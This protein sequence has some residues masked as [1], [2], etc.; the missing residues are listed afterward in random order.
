MQAMTNNKVVINETGKPI[1]SKTKVSTVT[2]DVNTESYHTSEVIRMMNQPTSV[3]CINTPNGSTAGDT[4]TSSA[5]NL[6]RGRG[7]LDNDIR[8]L[9]SNI[10]ERRAQLVHENSQAAPFTLTSINTPAAIS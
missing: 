10:R 4:S 6:D 1:S 8:K 5:L 2:D 3:R 7:E 9:L